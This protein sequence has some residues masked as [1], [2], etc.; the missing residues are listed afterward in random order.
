MKFFEREHRLIWQQEQSTHTPEE[1]E[2]T[3]HNTEPLSESDVQDIEEQRATQRAERAA[4]EAADSAAE[5]N[6]EQILS[7]ITSVE[8]LRTEI[9]RSKGGFTAGLEQMKQEIE[10]VFH[11]TE[12][13]EMQRSL[14]QSLDFISGLA[15][16]VETFMTGIPDS[17]DEEKS[18]AQYKAEVTAKHAR[19][20]QALE[21]KGDTRML[22]FLDSAFD[23]ANTKENVYELHAIN[24]MFTFYESVMLT[25]AGE[26][27]SSTAEEP[28]LV[29][30]TLGVL[31]VAPASIASL[32]EAITNKEWGKVF[33]EGM[34]MFGEVMSNFGDILANTFSGF[35]PEVLSFL[36]ESVRAMAGGNR[37]EF[38]RGMSTLAENGIVMIDETSQ[39]LIERPSSSR[40]LSEY[41]KRFGPKRDARMPYVSADKFM[42]ALTAKIIAEK[43]NLPTQTIDEQTTVSTLTESELVRYVSTLSIEPDV[44]PTPP[45]TTTEQPADT[46]EQTEQGENESEEAAESDSESEE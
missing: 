45:A 42:L 41:A 11:N 15:V 5:P 27:S 38:Y 1:P 25:G 20:K 40:V 43:S 44:A 21:Q 8:E 39:E 24:E 28:G 33:K 23:Q 30:K 7:T 2:Q 34:K 37:M 14:Q 26:S 13:P 46:T 31:G 19:L 22:E 6:P 4:Q 12:N 3:P 16:N 17:F 29:S 36:P 9:E 18:V 32:Q 35:G 10:G